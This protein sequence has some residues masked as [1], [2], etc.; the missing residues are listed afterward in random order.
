MSVPGRT[1]PAQPCQLVGPSTPPE[2][3]DGQQEHQC[4]EAEHCL[5]KRKMF[6]CVSNPQF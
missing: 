6:H 3:K 2:A 5:R 1:D 4:V